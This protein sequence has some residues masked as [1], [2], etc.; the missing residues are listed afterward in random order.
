MSVA[1]SPEPLS[2]VVYR[3][4]SVDQLDR[5]AGFA[6]SRLL[7]EPN[8]VLIRGIAQKHVIAQRLEKGV[9]HGEKAVNHQYIGNADCFLFRVKCPVVIL[10]ESLSCFPV[11]GNVPLYFF[12]E[13]LADTICSGEVEA[14]KAAF[15]LTN[16]FQSQQRRAVCSADGKAGGNGQPIPVFL[17]KRCHDPRIIGHA[18]LEDDMP[19]H[20]LAAHD[21]VKIVFYDGTA[22][23]CG[24][25]RL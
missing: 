9:C 7:G 6:L 14:Y 23:P 4:V 17:L 20:A 13:V 10:K 15:P 11:K 18:A 1:C 19:P 2:V 5:I 21:L 22:Q 12:R 3:H 24:N 8:R 16:R 25:I